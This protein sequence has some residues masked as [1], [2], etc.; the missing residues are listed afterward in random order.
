MAGPVEHDIIW[1][2]VEW[3]GWIVG[4]IASAVVGWV[5]RRYRNDRKLLHRLSHDMHGMREVIDEGIE[6]VSRLDLIEESQRA[7]ESEVKHIE[8]DIGK[9]RSNQHSVKR[10]QEQILE[11]LAGMET[12]IKWL[13]AKHGKTEAI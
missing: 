12:D 10:R 5:Y 13:C 11:R 8:G 7:M 6:V 2:I 1:R 9:L 4:A 3:A